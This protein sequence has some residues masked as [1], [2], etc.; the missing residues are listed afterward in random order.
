MSEIISAQAG[1]SEPKLQCEFDGRVLE[2]WNSPSDRY[3][4]SGLTLQKRK[5]DK[6]GGVTLFLMPRGSRIELYFAPDE[7]AA[8]EQL[9]AALLAA[10]MQQ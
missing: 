9:V 7:L 10:G 6:D 4:A 8:M 2:L 5:D 1:N 3:L